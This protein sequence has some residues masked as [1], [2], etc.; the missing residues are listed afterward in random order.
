MKKKVINKKTKVVKTV[1]KKE[2]WR[3]TR[4]SKLA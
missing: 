3:R 2:P 1:T 4:G